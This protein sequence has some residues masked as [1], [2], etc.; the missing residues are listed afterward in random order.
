M[1]ALP[2]HAR[3]AL[4]AWVMVTKDRTASDSSYGSTF[5]EVRSK[6]K[7]GVIVGSY[8]NIL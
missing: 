1:R 5:K 2:D 8:F 6:R 4:Q 3:K 7:R